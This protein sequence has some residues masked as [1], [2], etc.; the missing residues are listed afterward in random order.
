M[1][2]HIFSCPPLDV[3]EG[4]DQEVVLLL[5]GS[6]GPLTR[7]EILLRGGEGLGRTLSRLVRTGEVVEEEKDGQQL[8]RYPARS[9][10]S[11]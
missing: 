10:T 3:K 6:Q 8:Y 1:A 9:T 4:R 2:C 5:L 11:G 7:A